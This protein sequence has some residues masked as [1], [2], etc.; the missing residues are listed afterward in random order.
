MTGK[1]SLLDPLGDALPTTQTSATN[2]AAGQSVPLM[3]EHL[4]K[5]RNAIHAEEKTMKNATATIHTLTTKPAPPTTKDL[6]LFIV[7]WRRNVRRVVEILEAYRATSHSYRRHARIL[8]ER[9]SPFDGARIAALETAA[10]DVTTLCKSMRESLHNCG[11]LLASAAPTI[12]AGTTL[13]Q[14]CEILNVNTADR[15]DLTDDDG[16]IKIIYLHGL[17]DSAANRK[18][19]DKNGPLFQ[20]SQ[21]VFI[22]FLTNHA[23]GRKLGDSLWQ[24]G[25]MFADVPMYKQAAD[26]TMKR[27]PPRLHVVPATLNEAESGSVL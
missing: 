15:G 9:A 5:H 11:K 27:Q 13:A 8:R 25:G 23:E 10:A 22:D 24:P 21:Q 6:F 2:A 1:A 12:D 3:R 16:M 20:A 17:E 14:R 18:A 7:S 26:G 4:T 19:E